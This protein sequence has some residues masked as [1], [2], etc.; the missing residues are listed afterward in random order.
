MGTRL[1]KINVSSCGWLGGPAVK[2]TVLGVYFA[3]PPLYGNA[4]SRS[5]GSCVCDEMM[6]HRSPKA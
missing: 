1:P 5:V 3:G 2:I 6:V 4:I